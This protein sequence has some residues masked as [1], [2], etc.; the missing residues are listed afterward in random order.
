[1]KRML[2][3]CEVDVMWISSGWDTQRW[4][5]WLSWQGVEIIK[6]CWSEVSLEEALRSVCLM[7]YT[8][9]L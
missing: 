9:F 7:H 1:M 4:Q 6:E 8:F 2:I 3:G 5:E